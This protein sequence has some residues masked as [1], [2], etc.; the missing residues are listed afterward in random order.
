MS[1]AAQVANRERCAFAVHAY[2]NGTTATA[3]KF[4]LNIRTEPGGNWSA[5]YFAIFVATATLAVL[6]GLGCYNDIQA[7]NAAHA[8]K[9][10]KAK[11]Q[12][13]KVATDDATPTTATGS[14]DASVRN[15]GTHK[16]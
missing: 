8:K 14:R 4:S 15:G 6:M 12:A 1:A 3:V 10:T 11:V 13:S 16:M 7:A 9:K 5:I 2:P